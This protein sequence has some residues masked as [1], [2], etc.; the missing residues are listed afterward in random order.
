MINFD[1]YQATDIEATES[2]NLTQNQ[3]QVIKSF[4]YAAALKK[5]KT[6]DSEPSPV[7]HITQNNNQNISRPT[8]K[9]QS[10][11]NH[12]ENIKQVCFFTINPILFIYL[13]KIIG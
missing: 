9:I 13:K 1:L 5:I 12:H 4:G 8:K 11:L 10:E 3:S 6:S 2:N 7:E